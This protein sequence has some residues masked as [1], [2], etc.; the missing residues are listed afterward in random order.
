M[1]VLHRFV[2]FALALVLSL[3]TATATLAQ[4]DATPAAGT[5]AAGS[6]QAPVV[7]DAVPVYN[8]DTLEEV[9]T[10]TVDEIIDPFEDYSEF[11]AP[12]RGTRVV[13]VT[14]TVENTVENDSFDNPSYD[15]SLG[16]TQGLLYSSTYVGLP[17]D[18]DVV[19]FGD[20]DILGGES[21]S[22]TL[23]YVLGE[24]EE[25]GGLYYTAFGSYTLLAD[26]SGS[27]SP[28]VGETVTAYNAEGEEM[29]AVTV[30]DYVD[31]F[32]EYGEFSAPAR[33]ERV[34]A[35]TVEVENLLANDGFDFD[36]YDFSIQ[37]TEGL[38]VSTS[39]VTPAED[40]G[41]EEFEDVRLG[42]GESA[43]GT[44]F[45]VLPEDIEVAGIIYQPDTGIVVNIG[46]PRA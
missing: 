23:F 40:S 15:L 13:A 39:F 27:A 36:S 24:D 18:T 26:V 30:T 29:A 21:L 28:A 32:E 3:G 6:S 35:V 8:T 5:P 17:D 41:I 2:A 10:I 25:I 34:I 1:S 16:T 44:I 37:T 19:E 11:S 33:G 12:E 46:D 31:P 20:E 7:G 14:Y 22:G 4:D 9:G 45:F 42:G 43:E 38:L